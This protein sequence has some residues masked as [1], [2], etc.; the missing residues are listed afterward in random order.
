MEG[1]LKISN[2]LSFQNPEDN[3]VEGSQGG[4]GS[5]KRPHWQAVA[6]N[7][8]FGS[9]RFCRRHSGGKSM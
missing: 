9:L 2:A 1:D 5:P 6:T 4:W 7:L 3:V 8:E